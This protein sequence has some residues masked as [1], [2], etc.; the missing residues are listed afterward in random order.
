M[1]TLKTHSFF[2]DLQGLP[3]LTLD[4]TSQAKKP[5]SSGS[6]LLQNTVPILQTV[7]PQPR[8]RVVS[9]KSASRKEEPLVDPADFVGK[10]KELFSLLNDFFTE[11]HL[12]DIVVPIQNH[13]KSICLRTLEHLVT[14]Y[15]STH[16]VEYLRDE[17]DIVPW[18]VYE[19]YRDQLRYGGNKKKLDT[20]R[21]GDKF[22]FRKGDMEIV[23]SLCQLNFFRWAI[24]N[25]VIDWAL[26]HAEEI[27]V[28]MAKADAAKE[29]DKLERRQKRKRAI[30][31][32]SSPIILNV[33]IQVNL[34]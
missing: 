24:Q 5:S 6:L 34:V 21:R 9:P 31:I 26:E 10:P 20:F 4:N 18:N 12:R 32:R 8:K 17:R 27:K 11:A 15:S 1:Q 23:T 22:L 7:T 14:S 25:K 33:K 16:R 29:R 30:N 3:V 13:E 19:S 2:M 28:D